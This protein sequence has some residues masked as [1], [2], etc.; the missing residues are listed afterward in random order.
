MKPTKLELESLIDEVLSSTASAERHAELERLLRSDPDALDLFVR[1][2]QVHSALNR[3][4]PAWQ[5]PATA[6]GTTPGTTPLAA[7]ISPARTASHRAK[8]AIAAAAAAAI[9]L[10]STTAFWMASQEQPSVASFSAPNAGGLE[11][12]HPDNRNLPTGQLTE[13][14]TLR[15]HSGSASLKLRG[16]SEATLEG[17]TT[18]TTLSSHSLHLRNGSLTCSLH[19][20]L[21]FEIRTPL[22]KITTAN[23]TIKISANNDLPERIEVFD[24]K[25]QLTGQDVT[26][27]KPFAISLNA[28]QS[29]QTNTT[30]PASPSP[31]AARGK[32]A[33]PAAT[34]WILWSFDDTTVDPWTSTGNHPLSP[35]TLDTATNGKPELVAGVHGKAIRLAADQA[36]EA[37]WGKSV[38]DRTITIA[39]WIRLHGNEDNRTVSKPLFYIGCKAPANVLKTWNFASAVAPWMFENRNPEL[40]S[41]DTPNAEPAWHH[42]VA[43][44][45]HPSD[46]APTPFVTVHIDGKLAFKQPLRDFSPL[47]KDS[48]VI[49]FSGSIHQPELDEWLIIERTLTAEE[50]TRLAKGER[51]PLD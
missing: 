37:T 42:W 16:H 10:I 22:L 7:T 3:L 46:A 26:T 40:P 6:P 2:S 17:P 51:W 33:A 4:E 47:S 30:A 48:N 8:W 24:G 27:G 28:G 34:P 18:V 9:T 12:T 11:V 35:L 50:I 13:G 19:D 1:C 45:Q 25:A 38:G 43:S 5:D 39:G 21:T 14:S 20:P 49:R 15:I 29:Y 32:P 44:V 31:P 36:I 23:S 41:P